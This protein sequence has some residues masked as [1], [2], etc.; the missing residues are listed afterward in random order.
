MWPRSV[1]NF[2]VEVFGEDI[3]A[4]FKRAA[5]AESSKE[6]VGDT[7]GESSDDVD[8]LEGAVTSADS[9]TSRSWR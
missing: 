8:P 9:G 2:S 4:I 3:R 1:G 6:D 7:F 5:E